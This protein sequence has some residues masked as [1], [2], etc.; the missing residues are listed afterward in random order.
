RAAAG[1]VRGDGGAALECPAVPDRLGRGHLPAVRRGR[2]GGLLADAHPGLAAG[3]DAGEPGGVRGAAPVAGAGISQTGSGVTMMGGML[4]LLRAAPAGGE[5]DISEMILH[6][7][8]DSNYLE[9]P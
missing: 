3:G 8:A 6:H 9:L 1:G 2:G 4:P 5:F 7:L